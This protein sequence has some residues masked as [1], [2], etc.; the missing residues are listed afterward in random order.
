MKKNVLLAATAALA[1]ALPSIASAGNVVAT[2][3]SV[4]VS[5]FTGASHG[6]HVGAVAN[7]ITVTSGNV[8]AQAPKSITGNVKAG[9][10]NVTVGT[11]A[12]ASHKG[13]I[14]S[15]TTSVNATNGSVQ[16]QTQ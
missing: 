2:G 5:T 13:I 1:L 16:A 9:G 4:T 3:G 12:M 11:N 8:L 15:V 6:A 7:G 14:D 10:A